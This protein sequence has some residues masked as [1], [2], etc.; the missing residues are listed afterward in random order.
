[1]IR[2]DASGDVT[3]NGT[4][5]AD[6][7]TPT[8]NNGG[9][10]GGSIFITCE[11]ILGSGGKLLA[12]GGNSKT[13]NNGNGAGGR[14]AI[15]YD[16]TAQQTVSPVPDIQISARSGTG[17]GKEAD[18]GSVWL[19]DTYFLSTTLNANLSGQIWG[20]TSWSPASLTVDNTWVRF[21]EPGFVLDV[22]GNVLVTGT[23]GRLE[24]GGNAPVNTWGENM[25]VSEGAAPEML[26]GGNFELANGAT[27]S[28]F[29]TA[30]NPPAVPVGA[31]VDV[32]GDIVLGAN[33]KVYVHSHHTNGGS[34]R[35]TADDVTVASTA[36]F[37]AVAKG[38]AGGGQPKEN[39]YGPGGSDWAT[40]LQYC[41]GAGYGGF[42]GVNYRYLPGGVA[43]GSA[44]DPT[45]PGS[46][47]GCLKADSHGGRGGGL[48]HIE[49]SGDVSLDG[50]LI[51]DGE[52]LPGDKSGDNYQNGAGSG[53][54]INL[55]CRSINGAGTLSAK[56]GTAANDFCGDGGGGRIAIHYDKTVQDGLS[57]PGIK[58]DAR[59]GYRLLSRMGGLGSLWTSNGRLVSSPIVHSGELLSDDFAT[60]S[61]PSLSANAVWFRLP[62]VDVTVGGPVVVTGTNKDLHR[63]EGG[64]VTCTSVIATNAT[65]G[66][67]GMDEV[68]PSF[69]CDSV[70]ANNGGVV[71]DAG[72]STGGT[73]TVNGP[74]DLTAGSVMATYGS[75]FDPGPTSIVV[76]VNGA[77][78][79]D[80]TSQIHPWSHPTNGGSATFYVGSLSV[81][82][83]AQIN[84]DGK[85]FQG[86][87]GEKSDG[88]GPGRGFGD[89]N[90]Q[91]S[92]AGYGGH[93]GRCSFTARY[94]AD[95]GSSNAPAL[96]GSGGGYGYGRTYELS[97][98][99]GGLIA[100][101]ARGSMTIDG[102]V[103]ANG[104]PWGSQTV[105]NTRGGGSGGGIHLRCDKLLG[106]GA[107]V[108]RANGGGGSSGGSDGAGGGGRVAIWRV[109]GDEL[110]F[111]T[112][113]AKGT[114]GY[115]GGGTTAM[116]QDGTVVWGMLY[117]ERTLL[118]V[119]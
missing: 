103:T 61:L 107:G 58:M 6:G 39:G 20:V 32:T 68:R 60:W 24:I 65:V 11:R 16:T 114:G 69:I 89:A 84:A 88:F 4:I 82:A 119:R 71:C 63:F 73:F 5:T 99:G 76:Q 113:A 52:A 21:A 26:V 38:F 42:G 44:S 83:G 95:Y 100:I 33:C 34:P 22:D 36:K 51:A 31:R 66:V 9:G 30:T 116:S 47:G 93:G 55:T 104:E 97:G 2:I 105:Y 56:G 77:L 74:V 75:A 41:P 108:I 18:V 112:S 12:R 94:G 86:G 37:D 53:G 3:V 54:A 118:I 79:L 25:L 80:A 49:A 35:F 70:F 1:M 98:R 87:V 27:F 96:P 102:V 91:S 19:P 50:T 8:T 78:T 14:I 117:P 59:P 10:A 46:G 7:Q 15:H 28:V 106:S 81:P 57:V 40:D 43:Y 109:E 64:R 62:K 92:G 72:S 29:A 111:A 45:L 101:E 48:I 90:Q 67:V 13:S 85:G 115:T 17:T 110:L 23:L